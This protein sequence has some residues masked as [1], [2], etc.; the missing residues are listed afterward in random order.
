[1]KVLEASMP[2]LSH[3][4]LLLWESPSRADL[5]PMYVNI[6]FSQNSNLQ[7]LFW[8]FC[9]LSDRLSIINC[10][11]VTV[12][13]KTM[14]INLA[15]L[16]FN[17]L[18]EKLPVPFLAGISPGIPISYTNSNQRIFFIV[19]SWR[20][21]WNTADKMVYARNKERCYEGWRP[22]AGWFTLRCGSWPNFP[23][24]LA[25]PPRFHVSDW[26]Q[27]V[28]GRIQIAELI[29]GHDL[30]LSASPWVGKVCLNFALPFWTGFRHFWIY[31]KSL[32]F[33]GS[34]FHQ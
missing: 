2:I 32:L 27:Q 25:F 26:A 14:N 19:I 4:N 31:W 17:C 22:A 28:S 33:S 3:K 12:R 7:S 16:F 21:T 13:N 30:C 18:P 1:M 11:V 8:A 20:Q 23:S 24:G 6:E 9:L 5:S 10:K 34:S 15:G 29:A